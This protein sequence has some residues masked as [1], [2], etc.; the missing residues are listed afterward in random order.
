MTTA[1]APKPLLFDPI[2]TRAALKALHEP[3]SVYEV[4]VL[5]A[6]GARDYSPCTYRGFFNDHNAVAGALRQIET[7]DACYVTLNPCNPA[8]IARAANRLVKETKKGGATSDKDIA[9]RRGLLI[10]CDPVRPS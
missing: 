1:T 5:G 3:G 6:Q 10:D 4:R 8:L 9:I 7:W 2:K